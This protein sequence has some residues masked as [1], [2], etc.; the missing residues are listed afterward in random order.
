MGGEEKK[1]QAIFLFNLF[2]C[3]VLSPTYLILHLCYLVL[4]FFLCPLSMENIRASIGF[5]L[6]VAYSQMSISSPLLSPLQKWLIR[7]A[8]GHLCAEVCHHYDTVGSNGSKG[9]TILFFSAYL[10]SFIF[11]FSSKYIMI[12]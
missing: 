8:L 5:H 6:P 3:L 10:A 12:V 1:G 11:L 4:N 7:L 9:L 2:L